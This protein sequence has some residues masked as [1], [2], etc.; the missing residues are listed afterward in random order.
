M[1]RQSARGRRSRLLRS[2]RAIG[3]RTPSGPSWKTLRP[4]MSWGH[5]AEAKNIN[6]QRARLE[7]LAA[8]QVDAGAEATEA[9]S[10]R[11]ESVCTVPSPWN[12]VSRWPTVVQ[13]CLLRRG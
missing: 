1:R 5:S 11:R 9:D 4:G 2:L 7:S 13:F 12:R 10:A 6:R 3:S 8:S